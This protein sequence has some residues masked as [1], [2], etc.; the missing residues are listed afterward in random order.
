MKTFSILLLL[1]FSTP[2]VYGRIGETPQQC[3]V[4]YGE[5]IFTNVEDKVVGF[6]KGGLNIMTNF[7]GNGVTC[8]LII[9]AKA[10]KNILGIAD[11]LT[12]IELKTL[13]KANGGGSVWVESN[14]FLNTSWVTKDGLIQAQYDGIDHILYISTTKYVNQV[15]KENKEAEKKNL[16]DF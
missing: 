12:E 14:E 16:E 2:S 15:N 5:P 9:L 4:R 11:E 3:K 8:G 13:L 6:N 7:N 1:L 10:R